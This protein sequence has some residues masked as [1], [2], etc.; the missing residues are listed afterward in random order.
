MNNEEKI[1]A[2]SFL[3]DK[4]NEL[5]IKAFNEGLEDFRF[6]YYDICN[7]VVTYEGKRVFGIYMSKYDILMLEDVNYYEISD[8]PNIRQCYLLVQDFIFKTNIKLI[9]SKIVY[10]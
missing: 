7:M 4:F 9:H 5:G 2:N 8:I 3:E 6:K 10:D 1:E